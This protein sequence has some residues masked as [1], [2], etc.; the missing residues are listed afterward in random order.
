MEI[1]RNVRLRGL[2]WVG[3]V[4]RVKVEMVPKKAL[5]GYIGGRRP[6]GGP[7]GRWLDAVDRNTK[8]VLIGRN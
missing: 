5:K 8:R 6:V 4:I 7:R 1:T 2:K 3:H